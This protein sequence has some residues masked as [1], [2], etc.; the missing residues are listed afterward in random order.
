MPLWLTKFIE[1]TQRDT[2]LFAEINAHTAVAARN[3]LLSDLI[4]AY[5]AHAESV[6]Q[7]NEGGK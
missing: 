4:D 5:K 3:R 6:G 1:S 2:A 7:K